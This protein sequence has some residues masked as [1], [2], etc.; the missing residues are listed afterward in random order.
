VNQL[1]ILQTAEVIR[2]ARFFIGVDSGPA[3]LANALKV[4]GI[5]LLGR[6]SVFR[7]YMPFNGFFASASPL[8]K[9]VRNP[10][11]PVSELTVGEV[12]EALRY[13]ARASVARINVLA[14][15]SGNEGGAAG[16]TQT[17]AARSPSYEDDRECILTSGLFDAGWYALQYPDVIT[18]GMDPLD[19]F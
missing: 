2:R 11:G 8:V 14:P 19:H 5:V 9:M 7:Q 17:V 13:V 12:T 1:S 15:A 10:A 4:P 18:S 6:L 3:H 16:K